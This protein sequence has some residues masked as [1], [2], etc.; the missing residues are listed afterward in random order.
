MD[1]FG[2]FNNLIGQNV[3]TV[4]VS[5]PQGETHLKAFFCPYTQSLTQQ[6]LG[7]V[8]AI[9]PSYDP[10]EM[11][12]FIVRPQ[13]TGENIHYSFRESASNNPTISFWIQDQYFNDAPVKTYH[14]FNCRNPQLYFTDNKVVLYKNKAEV[15]RNESYKC[16]NIN[17]KEDF[18]V[19][20]M[21]IVQI[22]DVNNI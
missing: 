10:D 11:P 15:K 16:D 17:C 19:T 13:R 1:T 14:C 3:L 9:Y 22:R 4:L 8:T 5:K 20:F 21:G 7:Q 18:N 2:K 6:Y 12:Q